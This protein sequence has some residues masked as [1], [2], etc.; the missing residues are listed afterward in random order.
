MRRHDCIKRQLAVRFDIRGEFGERARI[1]RKLMVR[2]RLG[3]AMTREMLAAGSHSGLPHACNQ[4]T[5]QRNDG[6][7][8]GMEGAVTNDATASPV[9][10]KYRG[11]GEIDA[12]ASQFSGQHVTNASGGLQRCCCIT[13]PPFT[14]TTH[15]R[16]TCEAFATTLHPAPFVVGGNQQRREA[17]GMNFGSQRSQLCGRLIVA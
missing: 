2:I 3:P 9:E 14:K 12:T 17:Q 15:R 4:C 1:H 10:I 16:Q 13:I 11:E 8:V 6:L 7:W 5:S